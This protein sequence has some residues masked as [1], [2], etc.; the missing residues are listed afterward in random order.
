MKDRPLPSRA[1]L[2]TPPPAP[3]PAEPIMDETERRDEREEEVDKYDI[4]TLACTD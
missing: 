3:E 4:S 1:A 2:F